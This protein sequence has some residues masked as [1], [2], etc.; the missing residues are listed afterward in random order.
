MLLCY[1]LNYILATD[2]VV[3]GFSMETL[4]LKELDVV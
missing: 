2:L 4:M 1:S 3:P